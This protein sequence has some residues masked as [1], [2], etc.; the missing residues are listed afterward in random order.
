MYKSFVAVLIILFSGCSSTG[1]DRAEQN[2]MIKEYY[3][4]VISIEKVELSSEVKTGFVTG[5]SIGLLENLD[6]NHE[7]MIIGSVVG[8]FIGGLFTAI[9]EGGNEAYQYQLTSIQDGDF[10]LIQKEEIDTSSQCV[11]VRFA[12]EVSITP[13]SKEMC[14]PEENGLAAQ[15]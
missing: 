13:V 1:V 4:S 15:Y 6:G 7:D 10:T 11:Q 8:A 14:I 2:T 3:A 12:K 9:V 5:A